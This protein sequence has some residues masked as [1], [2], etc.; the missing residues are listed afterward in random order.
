MFF[1]VLAAASYRCKEKTEFI[2]LK[3]MLYTWNRSQ[4][5][6]C[7]KPCYL[8]RKTIKQ[9]NVLFLDF[10]TSV[11]CKHVG[12]LISYFVIFISNTESLLLI[13]TDTTPF[14]SYSK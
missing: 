8:K 3:Y 10:Q 14:T 13:W 12:T 5:L 7:L 9:V 11:S 6:K 2:L 1:K 4:I